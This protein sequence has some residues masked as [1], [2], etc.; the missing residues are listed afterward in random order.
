MQPGVT[1]FLNQWERLIVPFRDDGRLEIDERLP[2]AW[3]IERQAS[4]E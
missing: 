1:Y 4:A 2:P 3:P